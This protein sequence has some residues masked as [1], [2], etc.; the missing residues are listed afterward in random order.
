[1][2]RSDLHHWLSRIAP[3]QQRGMRL[4]HSEFFSVASTL[5]SDPGCLR[6]KLEDVLD[7]VVDQGL[8]RWVVDDCLV[9]LRDQLLPSSSLK[10]PGS[11]IPLVVDF[12][13]FSVGIGGR[14]KQP[15]TQHIA[16]N[17]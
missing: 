8:Y 13:V 17:A 3:T 7:C 1:M 9:A 5:E 16:I 10:V 2:G 15:M 14:F 6:G 11:P 4:R 12:R